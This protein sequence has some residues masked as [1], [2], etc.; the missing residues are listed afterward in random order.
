MHRCIKTSMLIVCLHIHTHMYIYIYIYIHVYIYT[1]SYACLTTSAI[2]SIPTVCIYLIYPSILLSDT[3]T[4]PVYILSQIMSPRRNLESVPNHWRGPEKQ[5]HLFPMHSFRSCFHCDSR[6][7][8]QLWYILES[9]KIRINTAIHDA[10]SNAKKPK[11]AFWHWIFGSIWRIQR[12]KGKIKRRKGVSNAE[13]VFSTPKGS[14]PPG[15]NGRTLVCV[16]VLCVCVYWEDHPCGHAVLNGM[17]G[18]GSCDAQAPIASL[19]ACF[20]M[21]AFP[22]PP[23]PWSWSFGPPLVLGP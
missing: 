18:G 14:T 4:L 19:R 2:Y 9:R 22:F 13:R 8:R 16:C 20:C 5:D 1:K 21:R 10:I 7:G 17:G 23:L 12:R 15:G 11:T 6:A 3:S